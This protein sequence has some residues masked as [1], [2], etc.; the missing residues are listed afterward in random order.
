MTDTPAKTTAADPF[1]ESITQSLLVEKSRLELAMR[2]VPGSLAIR[3]MYFEVLNR[4]SQSHLGWFF[5]VFPEISTP[6]LFRSASS[7]VFNLQQIYLNYIWGTQ[8]FYY[9]EYG[10]DIPRPNR[11]LDLGAYC[12]YTAVYFANRFPEAQI[13]CVEPSASSFRLL[14]ANTAPY[15]NIRCLPAAVWHERAELK[16]AGQLLGDWGNF[17]SSTGGFAAERV[18]PGYTI[19]DILQMH[20]WTGADF[21]K[22]VVENASVPILSNPVRPWL[23]ELTCVATKPVAGSWPHPDD[24]ATL[25]A[26]F[27]GGEFEQSSHGAELIIFTRRSRSGAEPPTAPPPLRLIPSPPQTR[28][29]TLSNLSNHPDFYRF[30][31]TGIQFVASTSDRPPASVRFRLPFAGH[32][33]FCATIRTGPAPSGTATLSLRITSVESGA[34]VL[35]AHH[36]LIAGSAFEWSLEFTPLHGEHETTLSAQKS[37]GD[38]GWVQFVDARFQ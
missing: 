22:C 37:E 34:E 28:Y 5:A 32:R 23:T 9:G 14:L 12:G 25:R 1:D 16:Q 18:V 31:E 17:F 6:L 15:P 8:S 20:G 11:I 29:F 10:F 35:A 2:S 27:P 13:I 3:T 33:R 7:D 30:D 24:E 38:R 19:S 4:L 36:S 21:I 26:A